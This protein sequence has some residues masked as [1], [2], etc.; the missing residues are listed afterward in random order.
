LP[1]LFAPEQ[2]TFVLG[3]ALSTP[4]AQA[5]FPEHSVLQVLPPQRMEPPHD[6][7]PLQ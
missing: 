4:C 2:T 1:Q 3:A 5:L 7:F 6:L